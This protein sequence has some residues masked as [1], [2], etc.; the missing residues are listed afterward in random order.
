MRGSTLAAAL[1]LLLGGC[2]SAPVAPSS[3]PPAASR[4]FQF[5]RKPTLVRCG[6]R[7]CFRLEFNAVDKNDNPAEIPLDPEQMRRSMRVFELDAEGREQTDQRDR[8]EGFVPFHVRFLKNDQGQT[9]DGNYSMVLLDLSGSMRRTLPSGRTRFEAAQAAVERYIADFQKDVDHLAVVPFESKG[10]SQG[11]QNSRF[12]DNVDDIRRDLRRLTPR[13]NGNTALY[14]AIVEA[15]NVLQKEKRGSRNVSLVVLTD[16]KNDVGHPGD[17]IGLLTER[18]RDQ[19]KKAEEEAGIE[20]ITIGFGSGHDSSFDP[21]TLRELAWPSRVNYYSAADQRELEDAFAKARRKQTSRIQLTFGPVREQK[22]ELAGLQSL[23]FRAILD[24]P[25]GTLFS[26]ESP[27]W[28]GPPLGI[29]SWESDLDGSE[30]K[31]FIV[32]SPEPPPSLMVRL[33]RRLAVFF[34]YLVVLAGLWFGFPRLLWPE[35]Y[36]PQGVSAGIPKTVGLAAPSTRI[37]RPP[38]PPPRSSPAAPPQD[39]RQPAWADRKPRPGDPKVTIAPRTKARTR[40][41]TTPDDPRKPSD[42]TV[43]NPPAKG[44]DDE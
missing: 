17:D 6:D 14:S 15:L 3:L 42:A 10:V 27:P 21:D 8:G 38:P 30:N 11:I 35:R 2:A 12:L 36:L 43:Y 28:T 4:H 34:G 13:P 29:P 9:F 23:S 19:V 37:P 20:V 26:G 39:K 1:W 25:D 31:D 18:E 22:S 16:G 5:S 24:A 40:R 44:D 7:P 41:R 32:H 33:G